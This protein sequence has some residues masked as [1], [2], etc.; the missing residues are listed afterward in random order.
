MHEVGHFSGLG[1]IYNPGFP[2]YLPFMGTDND[3]VTMYGFIRNGEVVKRDLDVPD[4]S[5][6]GYIYRNIPRTRMDVVLI[7]DGAGNFASPSA[8]NG[9]VPAKN[10]A[11]ALIQKMRTGDRVGV[12]RLPNTIISPL[13]TIQDSAS[14]SG[15]F[16]YR[17]QAG[18]FVAHRKM[19]MLK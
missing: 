3:T 18:D 5:G 10:N 14:R 1:D 11:A 13:T 16:F 7:F 4:T 12:I 2:Q 9:F 19:M 8:Y 6:I 15:V 17:L